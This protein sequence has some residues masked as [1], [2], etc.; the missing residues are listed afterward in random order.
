MVDGQPIDLGPTLFL[1]DI[2]DNHDLIRARNL[3]VYA[4][5]IDL[6]AQILGTLVVGETALGQD[7]DG[8]VALLHQQRAAFI[9]HD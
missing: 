2:I 3:V 9:G 8:A 5:R 4:A 6:D 1:C 7:A